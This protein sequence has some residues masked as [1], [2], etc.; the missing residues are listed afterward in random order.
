MSC[1][2]KK[3]CIILDNNISYLTKFK[4]FNI[5]YLKSLIYCMK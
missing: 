1:V 3:L 4:Y 5:H 2:L